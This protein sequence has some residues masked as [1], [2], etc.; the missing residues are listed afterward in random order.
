[1]TGKF[2]GAAHYRCNIEFQISKTIP[3]VFH[4]LNYDSHFIIERLANTFPGKIDIIPKTSEDYISFSKEMCKSIFNTD[5]END[6]IDKNEN[7]KKY[8]DN[9]RLRFIDSYRFLQ[10]SLAKLAQYLPSDKQ[11]ITRKEWKHLSEHD[12]HLS[13]QKGVYPYTYMNSWEKFNEKKLPNK[14]D[15]YDDLNDC[16]ISDEQYE[17]AQNV[18]D[19]FNIESMREYTSLYL[20]TDVLLLADIFENF[21]DNC[22]NLYELDPAH[23][24][25]LPGYSWDCMLK[26]THVQVELFT[27]IDKMLFVE[28]GVRGGISQCSKR[29]SEANNE[30]MG[31]D[32]D[33]NKLSK[34]L[35]YFD[36]N[37]LYGWAMTQPLPISDYS[38][39]ST[40]FYENIEEFESNV[41]KIPDDAEYGFMF[42]ID[43][44]YPQNLHDLHNDYPF[45]SEHLNVGNSSQKKL[46]L[47]LHDKKNYVIH[48]RMLKAV[49]KHG[50]KVKKIHKIL[51]FKQSTWLNEYIMLNT[52]ER[53]KSKTDFEKN[54]YK[55]MNNAISGKTLEN[56][57]KRVDIKLVSKWDGRFG[58]QELIGKPNF[59][60]NIIFNPNLVACEL[61]R[62]NININKPMIVGF[63]ILELSKLLMYE[64]HYDFMLKHFNTENCKLLY[65]DTDSFMYEITGE[66][67]YEFIRNNPDKFDTSD[68]PLG[69]PYGINQNNKKVIGLMKD[70]NS[71][72]IMI[73]FI[74]LRSKMYTYRMHEKSKVIKK[75]KGVKK[76]VLKNTISFEDYKECINENCVVV[77]SQN[78][79]KS[80]LHNVYTISNFKVA[81]AWGHYSSFS[82]GTL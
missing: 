23:Y 7:D 54:L 80:H 38:W 12:F 3:I 50:L 71:G 69:N 22:I 26:Q 30:Y 37:N 61:S 19:T 48:Y 11:V 29:H 82:L 79:I 16:D 32:Y 8:R 5:E 53:A 60:R 43:I 9:L 28:K 15:F 2:R 36:V 41:L 52:N 17:F 51:R 56:V 55:L 13:T 27:D 47:T 68:F 59:K 44:E 74:G 46:V 65:T 14:K 21:R 64:F 24:F 35:M 40:D 70:E 39:I 4:N 77:T 10:C 6:L 18:W 58:L 1:M 63:S 66:N 57:R 42:E 81:L 75:A 25:T 33:K 49:I 67:I 20:K 45:C 76:H 34:Y 73:E 62:L 78:S 72:K 31:T